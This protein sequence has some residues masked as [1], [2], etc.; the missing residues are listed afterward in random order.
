M[1]P[2]MNLGDIQFSG[3]AG[4]HG[5][6]N[7]RPQQPYEDMTGMVSVNIPS[8]QYYQFNQYQQM[9]QNA[10]GDYQFP[11]VSMNLS[12]P[13]GGQQ[14]EQDVMAK[15]EPNSQSPPSQDSTAIPSIPTS[16][17]TMSFNS[18]STPATAQWEPTSATMPSV[19]TGLYAP[20]SSE[21]HAFVD[22]HAAAEALQQYQEEHGDESD[23]NEEHFSLH[24]ELVS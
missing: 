11:Q 21:E 7:Q 13:T 1:A 24:G 2:Q 6:T 17:S 23:S 3:N 16:G 14:D 9:M 4:F 10:E 15:P 22:S 5:Q 8:D 18:Q 20:L 12:Q 19:G